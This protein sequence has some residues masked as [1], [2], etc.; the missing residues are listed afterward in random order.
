M[1]PHGEANHIPTH[2]CCSCF[3]AR[4]PRQEQHANT[5]VKFWTQNFQTPVIF[6]LCAA[7][8]SISGS[9]ASRARHSAPS[10]AVRSRSSSVP[11]VLCKSEGVPCM[12]TYPRTLMRREKP[13]DMIVGR[14]THLSVMFFPTSQSS[15]FGLKIQHLSSPQR[16][17]AACVKP[18]AISPAAN[19][20]AMRSPPSCRK[21]SFV[22]ACATSA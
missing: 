13:S 8:C 19:G 16:R 21:F 18:S 1:T 15:S 12:G 9:R 22:K 6:R 2:D 5:S 3:P 20:R 11:V 14:P 4:R 10:R 7:A 17:D